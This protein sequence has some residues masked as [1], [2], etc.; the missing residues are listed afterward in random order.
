MENVD[1]DF[2]FC[3]LYNFNNLDRSSP[4]TYESVKALFKR[5]SKKIDVNVTPHMMRHSHATELLRS[6]VAIEIVSKRLGHRSI[7]TTKKIYEHLT[8]EDLK[9]ELHRHRDESALLR[10][11][12]NTDTESC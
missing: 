1:S 10:T 9:N 2:V 4:T 3:N 6:G 12:Y 5:I 8:A 11:L 7:E